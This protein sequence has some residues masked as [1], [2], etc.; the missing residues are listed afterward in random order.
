[1]RSVRS[2]GSKM[3]SMETALRTRR[4]LMAVGAVGLVA[5]PTLMLLGHG[6]VVQS[7]L[8]AAI[9]DPTSILADR[10]PGRRAPGALTQTKLRY[11]RLGVGQHRKPTERVLG[12]ART[13]PIGAAPLGDAI[14]PLIDMPL[15]SSP[16]IFSG[17]VDEG[18]VLNGP[19]VSGFG[20]APVAGIGIVGGGGG[21]GGGGGVGSGRPSA[22]PVSAIPEPST[23][24]MTILGFFA[25]GVGLRRRRV[26]VS[27]VLKRSF[28]STRGSL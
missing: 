14:D 11:I 5:V 22:Q 19:G 2:K 24:L 28:R 10:S 12:Q 3:R 15:N 9:A 1:M 18:P 6:M 26:R 27:V 8:A 17:I 20:S 23:W 21:G 25:A 4:R 16:G 7:A 13:R